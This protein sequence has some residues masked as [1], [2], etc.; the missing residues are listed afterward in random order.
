LTP[1]PLTLVQRN[2]STL[3]EGMHRKGLK[4]ERTESIIV[5]RLD[6]FGY[7]TD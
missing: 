5:D 4:Q 6:T 7:Q 2:N 1:S 3:N